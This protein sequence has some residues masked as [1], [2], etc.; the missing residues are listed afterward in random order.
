ML[1]ECA[2]ALN[3]KKYYRSAHVFEIICV[4]M[5]YIEESKNIQMMDRNVPEGAALHQAKVG[6]GKE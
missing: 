2:N 3:K 5:H 1:R 6:L 4:K